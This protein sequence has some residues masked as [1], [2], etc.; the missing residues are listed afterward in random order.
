MATCIP[1]EFDQARS[2]LPL[3]LN[4]KVGV[5][6]VGSIQKGKEEV[7]EDYSRMTNKREKEEEEEEKKR[8][9]GKGKERG[10]W[11]MEMW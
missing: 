5:Y 6:A 11:E 3:R 7:D 1:L 8:S 9:I 2:R 4:H 10:C